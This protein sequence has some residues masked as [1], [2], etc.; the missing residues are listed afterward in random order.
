MRFYKLVII[1]LLLAAPC[2]YAQTDIDTDIF[3]GRISPPT[4]PPPSLSMLQPASVGTMTAV[5]MDVQQPAA[6]P[7]PRYQILLNP[8]YVDSD[9]A[10]TGVFTTGVILP[11]QRVRATV[12]YSYID[13]T[14]GNDHLDSYGGAVRWKAWARE[15]AG[16]TVV[17][18]HSDTRDVNR[19]TQAGLAGEVLVR[20]PLTVG[21]DLRWARKS[22]SAS[23]TDDLI[24]VINAGLNLGKV[25]L[26]ASYTF[27]ND[28]DGQNDFGAQIEIPLAM[29]AL[30]GALS[31]HGT[32][33][34]GFARKFDFD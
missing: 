5:I 21:A 18:S 31:K 23:E 22:S 1:A 27:R 30:S 25:I 2:L 24:P 33:R 14:A 28:V 7:A 12:S 19:K 13:P 11:A 20:G 17:G 9:A 16:L 4:P 10:T 6:P 29:G 8:V 26:G 15:R 3:A 32:W 34:F